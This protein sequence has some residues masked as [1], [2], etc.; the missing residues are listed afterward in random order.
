M[1]TPESIYN[2]RILKLYAVYMNRYYPQVDVDAIAREAGITKYQIEDSGCWF[3]QEEVD[4]YYETAVKATRNPNLARDVG[5]Y[6]VTTNT[7]GPVKQ[8]ALGMLNT[9][10][11]YLL[12]NKLYS[13]LSRGARVNVRKLESNKVE[14]L[15]SPEEGVQEKPYQCENRLG[16][17]E[18]LASLFTGKYADIVHDQCVHRGDDQC[19]YIASW[20]VLPHQKWMRALKI[21]VAVEVG[22]A[23]AGLFLWPGTVWWA[24]NA[25][26]VI[27]LMAAGLYAARL[28]R[29]EL[30]RTI[31]NQGNAA[32]DHIREIDVR[33]RGALL[34][35]KIGQAT[36][37]LLDVDM[38][39]QVV[40]S[41]I[42]KQLD[43][44]RG[45]IMLSDESRKRLV[46]TAGFGFDQEKTALLH[47]TQFRLDHHDAKG[48]FIQVYREQRPILVDDVSKMKA[49]LSDRSR[50]FA[51]Q[52]GS[53]SLICLPI[54]YENHSL[55]ILAVD[56]INTKRPLTQSDMNLLMGVAYQTAVSI[57]GARAHKKLQDSE[58]RYRSLYE[59][60]PTAYFSISVDETTILN[61][62]AAASNLLGHPRNRMIGFCLLDFFASDRDNRLKAQRIQQALEQGRAVHAEEIQLF[63]QE[64]RVVWTNFSME[65]FRD[66]DGRIVEGRC[67]LV[68]TTERKQLEEKLRHAQ[69]MEAVGTLAGGVA[70]DL[71]NILSAIVSYPDL[72]LMDIGKESKMYEPLIK[73]QMAGLRAAAI[74]QDLLTLARRGLQLQEVITINAVVKEFL[75]GPE[76]DNLKS[77]HPG[78]TIIPQLGEHLPAIRGSSVHLVKSLIN[79]VMNAAEA[80]PDG[81]QIVI[82]SEFL[83]LKGDSSQKDHEQPPGDYVVLSIIDNGT[84]I[85]EE[86]IPRI[87]EPFYTNKVMGRSGTGLGMAIV[88]ATMEDHNGFV[89]VKSTVGKGTIVRLF[90]PATKETHA[91][92]PEM[93]KIEALMG[94]GEAIL[95]V[96]DEKDHREIAYQMLSRLNYKVTAVGGVQE[97]LALAERET[98]QLVVLD[99]VLGREMDGLDL[100]R[101]MLALNPKQKGL[102]I[103]GYSESKRVKKALELGLGGYIRKPFSLR[104]L[105]SAVR[106]ELKKE[107]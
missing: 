95:V 59:K 82:I 23:I 5:R 31:Q 66:P 76:H 63:H 37:E 85:P 50:L 81:G 2:S 47:K 62:N 8:H 91:P 39:A 74:V 24:I 38:L 72:M 46:F 34:I 104:H 70:H 98:F 22:A 7:A 42:E 69:K 51:E 19:R 20:E 17:F 41:Q 80:M 10:S 79:I 60:A 67:V 54:V 32:E 89:D 43:F 71:S 90:F 65:P 99:M 92:K 103:S 83:T 77:N 86:D 29:Q 87:F 48:L 64:G 1:N 12:L 11:I 3:D 45:I 61:C 94:D 52:I 40:V 97:A 73:V 18:S 107:R 78:I 21:G 105:A 93:P 100:Y 44:D 96:E 68:D 30:I 33:Y 75:T 16:T 49:S 36:S 4:L 58:E 106:A 14:I 28:G 13:M 102:I 101:R 53:R 27:V 55:G 26:A 9:S 84:G 15:V 35:Q 25:A 56:N 88:M 57:F 6:A